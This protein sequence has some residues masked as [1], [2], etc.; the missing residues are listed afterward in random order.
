[1]GSEKDPDMTDCEDS[2]ETLQRAEC[3]AKVRRGIV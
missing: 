3:V 1:M 2:V